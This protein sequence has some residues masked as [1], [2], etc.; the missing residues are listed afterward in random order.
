M[1]VRFPNGHAVTYKRAGYL[2]NRG[3]GWELYTGEGGDWIASIQESAGAM[4]ETTSPSKVENPTMTIGLT[5]AEAMEMV[6]RMLE[7]HTCPAG[8]GED[9]ARMKA[10]LRSFDARSW[11]WNE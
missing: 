2:D 11:E 4:I 7:N 8:A 9:T 6:V 3:P 1:T 10:A 5:D